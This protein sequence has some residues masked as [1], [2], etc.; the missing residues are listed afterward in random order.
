[1]RVFL[2]SSKRIYT[3]AGEGP[4]TYSVAKAFGE[5]LK[6]AIQSKGWTVRAFDRK[7]STGNG[8]VGHVCRGASA[9]P[10]ANTLTEWA[11]ALDMSNQEIGE[12]LKLADISRAKH[13]PRRAAGT[14]H[15]ERRAR[16]AEDAL[17]AFFRAASDSGFPIPE[18]V[19]HA[20]EAIR[21]ERQR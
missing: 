17:L 2:L 1:M 10:D 13:T 12:L 14:E 21:K 16:A 9:P 11:R 18:S 5:M 7:F 19:R 3:L 4:L 20:V 8:Y 15:L 6:Q